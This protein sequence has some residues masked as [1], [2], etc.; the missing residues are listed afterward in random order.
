MEVGTLKLASESLQNRMIVVIYELVLE[1]YLNSFH[2]ILRFLRP[3]GSGNLLMV[4]TMSKAP[5]K[6]FV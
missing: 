5:I 1:S 3:S 4:K 6:S 2:H